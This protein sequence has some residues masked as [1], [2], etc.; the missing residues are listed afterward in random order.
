MAEPSFHLLDS[1][2]SG[3]TADIYF[4]RTVDI[5][6]AEEINP[7]V[8]MEIFPSKPGVLCGIKEVKEL[9]AKVLTPEREVWALSEGGTFVRKEVVLRITAP[10]LSFGLYETGMLGI[11]A[12]CSG[13]ATAAREC[14]EAAQGIPVISFGARHVHPRVAGIMDYAAVV[15]GCAG[16]SSIEGAK[17]AGTPPSG[18]M[19]HALIIVMGDTV[20][21]T[22]A[23]DKHMPTEAVRVSLV[24]TFKDEAEESLNVAQAL[25]GR[26]YGVRLDTPSERGRVTADLVKEVRARLDQAGFPE[27]KIFVS[28]GFDPERIAAFVSNKVPVDSFGVGAYISGASPIDFTGDLHE[29]EGRAVAKRGRIPGITPNP[30]LERIL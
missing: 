9:L 10:Y 24:D 12:H 1:V 7:T 4:Q 14:A 30:R 22:M 29:V 19:P 27:V 15:G 23:F 21:A 20:T 3:E 11:L 13:W 2:L 26:L 17:L 6:K 25:G 8:T 28:G 5:L 16:C 18:T